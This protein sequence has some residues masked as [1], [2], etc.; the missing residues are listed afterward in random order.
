MAGRVLP[1]GGQYSGIDF[2]VLSPLSPRLNLNHLE[3]TK[4]RYTTQDRE[5]DHIT[6]INHAAE[7]RSVKSRIEETQIW[8]LRGQERQEL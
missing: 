4:Y 7:T 5:E 2:P 6:A 3:R 1:S 8:Y